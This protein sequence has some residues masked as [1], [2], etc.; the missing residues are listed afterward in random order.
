M[1]FF[2][3]FEIL[4]KNIS[5]FSNGLTKFGFSV[6]RLMNNLPPQV[7]FVV[8]DLFFERSAEITVHMSVRNAHTNAP[9]VS[10]NMGN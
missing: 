5:R 8:H 10:W 2:V 6:L 3:H 7:E 9:R 1:I 4:K